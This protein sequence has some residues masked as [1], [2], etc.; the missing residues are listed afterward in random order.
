M[1]A[2]GVHELLW[3]FS[4]ARAV[5]LG[6]PFF[7]LLGDINIK[8]VVYIDFFRFMYY[9]ISVS[10]QRIVRWLIFLLI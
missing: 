10:N 3:A 6:R 8:M 9:N 4:E 1:R 2:G 7:I 5:R